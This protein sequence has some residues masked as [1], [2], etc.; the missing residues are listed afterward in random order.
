[1][2]RF[3]MRAVLTGLGLIATSGAWATC[4]SQLSSYYQ[5][6]TDSCRTNIRTNYPDCFASSDSSS[7]SLQIAGTSVQQVSAISS[8]VASRMLSAPPSGAKVAASKFD[9][10]GMAAGNGAQKFN[11]WGNLNSTRSSYGGNSALNSTDKTSSD[12]VNTVLG[13]DYGFAPNMVIG[14]SAAFDRSSGSIGTRAVGS[15]TKGDMY[16]PYF[17]WQISKE[18][19]LDLSAGWGEGNFTSS[20]TKVDS[21]R[22][23]AA[24]NLSYNKWLNNYQVTGKVGYL[25]AKEKYDNIVNAGGTQNGTSSSNSVDQLRLGVDVGYWMNGVM[26]FVG[27]AYTTDSRKAS[28]AVAGF[29]DNNK[30]GKDAFVLSLGANFFSLAKGVTGGVVYTTESGRSNGKNDMLGA[31]VSFRF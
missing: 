30:L 13:F 29:V 11:V 24:A 16:A 10:S 28:S 5:C 1:M 8:A 6:T 20:A 18:M 4:S 23:F 21:K 3:F 26:P 15:T 17:G 22:D 19:A 2:T 25:M 12:I 14:F 31:N 7:S 27:L 9:E